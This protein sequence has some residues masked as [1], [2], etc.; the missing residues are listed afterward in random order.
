MKSWKKHT[1]TNSIFIASCLLLLASCET[2]NKE[3]ELYVA[4]VGNS[5]LSKKELVAS[6]NVENGSTKY[7]KE[8]IK[9]WI[10]TEVLSQVAEEK[11]LLDNENFG[12]IITQTKKELAAVA[13]IRNFLKDKSINFSDNELKTFFNKNQK[14][15]Q[16]NSTAYVVNIITFNN[17]GKAINFRNKGILEGWNEAINLFKKDSSVLEI[18]HNKIYQDYHIQSKV[19]ARILKG[20][21]N[22][23]I[24]PVIKTELNNFVVV[25][26]ID[27]IP[28]NTIPKFKYLKEKV[29]ER[30]LILKQK[31]I[32]KHY[33]DSLL[34]EKKVKIY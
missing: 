2:K 12:N 34:T 14:D 27:K 19:L 10:E 18:G 7:R 24:S 28:K 25:Q 3:K 31:E 21:Y 30:Y 17:E 9:N 20:Q 5:K 15:Y 6:T 16:N 33:I 11:N 13:A 1:K 26:Q 4:E 8:Y 22:K 23:E 29:K 32:V